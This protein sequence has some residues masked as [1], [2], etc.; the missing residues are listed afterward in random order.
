MENEEERSLTY[1]KWED[2]LLQD[3]NEL[4]LESLNHDLGSA[5]YVIPAKALRAGTNY[6]LTLWYSNFLGFVGKSLLEF[7]TD[8]NRL[9]LAVKFVGESANYYI[10][11]TIEFDA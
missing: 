10:F 5:V 8:P 6:S 1:L 2:N 9:Q 11:E 4:L 3:E 7:E